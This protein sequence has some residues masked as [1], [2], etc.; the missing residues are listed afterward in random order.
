MEKIALV[1]MTGALDKAKN[2]EKAAHHLR[3]AAQGGARIVCLQELFNTVYFC[4]QDD[5]TNF[6]FAETIPGPSTDAIGKIAREQQIVVIAPIYEQDATL[7]GRRYNSAAV[8]GT[9]GEVEGVYRKHSIPNVCTESIAA[10]EKFYFAPGNLGFPVFPTSFG[11]KFGLIICYDRHFPEHSRSIAL[12]GADILFIP[13]CTWG[14]SQPIWEIEL[15]GHAVFNL[16][17]VAGVNRVGQDEGES[18]SCFGSSMIINPRGEVIAKASD[19]DEE[20]LFGDIDL[21]MISKVRSD[22]GLYRDRRPETYGALVE[23]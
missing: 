13:T 4:R 6:E 1:Q 18:A 21:D 5:S 22:W 7:K 19:R 9:D 2:L 14:M 15:K 17:Y 12:N 3:T 16:F 10:N 23:L 8:I 20:V 11:V